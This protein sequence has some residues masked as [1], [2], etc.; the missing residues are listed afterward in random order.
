MMFGYDGNAEAKFR[1]SARLA[2]DPNL[3]R[4]SLDNALTDGKP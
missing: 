1:A 2:F 3:T 4:V